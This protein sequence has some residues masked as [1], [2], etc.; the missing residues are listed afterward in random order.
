MLGFWL[1]GCVLGDSV[2]SVREGKKENNCSSCQNGPRTQGTKH[3]GVPAEGWKFHPSVAWSWKATL[4]TE[5]FRGGS[6]LLTHCSV[7]SRHS[8]KGSFGH[9]LKVLSVSSFSA[10]LVKIFLGCLVHLHFGSECRPCKCC[11]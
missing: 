11:M 4:I 3:Q 1:G 9:P 10:L 2:N 7:S 6:G 5:L 8:E